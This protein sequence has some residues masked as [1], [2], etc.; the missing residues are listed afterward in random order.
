MTTLVAKKTFSIKSEIATQLDKYNNKSKFVNE[1]LSFYIDYLDSF[2][3]YKEGFLENKINEA[4]NWEFYDINLSKNNNINKIKFEDH[5]EK[6]EKELLLA[7][8]D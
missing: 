5:S 8:N 6:L 3:K 2:K 4:L 7:V 1:A